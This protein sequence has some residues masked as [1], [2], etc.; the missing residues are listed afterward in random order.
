M[1]YSVLMSVYIKD[2]PLWLEEA[3]LS[4]FN[5]TIPTNNF[6]IVKDGPLTK[7]LDQILTK[8]QKQYPETIKIIPL[9]KNVGLGLALNRGITECENELIARIDS[10][11]IS[12]P[13]RIEEQLKLFVKDKELSMVGTLATEFKDDINDI[14][15]YAT[16]PETND[17]II[18]YAKKRNPF[19]HP[20][21][22]FKK[23]AVL[24]A[25]NYQSC[26]LCEDYD[27]W[28]RMIQN[29]NKCY[30]IQEYLHYWRISDD[31]YKRRSGMKYLKSILAFLKRQYK[32]KFLSRK[33]YYSAVIIRS[34]VYLIPNKLRAF[35]YKNFLRKKS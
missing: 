1:N 26:H 15:G 32:N 22:M 33:E 25:G 17:A 34:I 30:N 2:N 7:E 24:Q 35:I 23:Q 20:S 10:D 11:D 19:C 18:S 8:Y 28:I 13:N 5:Q 29:H 3:I 12:K 9:E 27:L 6:V 16:F 4:I 21:V 14:C 31:F